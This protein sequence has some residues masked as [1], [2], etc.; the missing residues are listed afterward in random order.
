VESA[1]TRH[2]ILGVLPG[3]ETRKIRLEY[4]AKAP[5]CGPN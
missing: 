1:I 4:D 3:A 5:R 2:D